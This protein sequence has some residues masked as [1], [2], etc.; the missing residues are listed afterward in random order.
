VQEMLSG[1][2]TSAAS[3]GSPCAMG[4]EPDAQEINKQNELNLCEK[5]QDSFNNA[6]LTKILENVGLQNIK[7]RYMRA[8]L[9]SVIT[10]MYLSD[11]IVVDRA[12]IPN[13][14]IRQQLRRITYDAVN[15][16]L[17]KL[18]NNSGEMSRESRYLM[19]CLYTAI[20]DYDIAVEIDVL[21]NLR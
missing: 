13:V 2:E 1:G 17:Q 7:D 4:G 16:A 15:Y 10:Q 12:R 20:N 11:F 14:L 8:T 18:R 5:E 6:E 21:R 9:T 3:L 19:A